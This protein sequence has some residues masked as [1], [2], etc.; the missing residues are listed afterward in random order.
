LKRGIVLVALVIG[1]CATAPAPP[2]QDAVPFQLLHAQVWVPGTIEAAAPSLFILDTGAQATILADDYARALGLA[3]LPSDYTATG[4]TGNPIDL[5]VVNIIHVQLGGETFTLGPVGVLSMTSISLRQ[6]R[7]LTAVLGHDLLV[8]RITEID[9]EQRVVRFHDPETY[10]APADFISVPFRFNQGLPVIDA[11]IAMDDGRKLP[12]R[13]GV[14]SGDRGALD[15]KQAFA[16]ENHLETS[17]G[18]EVSFGLNIGGSIRSRIFRIAQLDVAG[19]SLRLP[20]TTS[21]STSGGAFADPEIDG[22]LGAEVLRRF[23]LVVDDRHSR[24][25]IRPNRHM[26]EP[27][28]FD[29]SGIVMDARDNHFDH[30]II[31]AV[32]PH[33]PADDAGVRP[34]DELVAIDGHAALP[35]QFPAIRERF[36]VPNQR[37]VLKLMRDGRRFDVAIVTRTLL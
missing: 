24:L 2:P 8:Q 20:I 1:G 33:S 37:H 23:T 3:V 13:V 26:D 31:S 17:H 19:A 29:A 16:D 18:I 34:G 15:L 36:T 4:P 14:D 7:P 9:Y 10:V 32:I 28:D 5:S 35:A 22:L 21:T 11:E 12:V 30:T 6:G 27:F 25:F